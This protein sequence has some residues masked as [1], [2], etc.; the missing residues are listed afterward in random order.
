VPLHPD[1]AVTLEACCILIRERIEEAKG[2]KR[3]EN[4]VCTSLE[5][6]SMTVSEMSY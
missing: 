6:F 2:E 1:P 5:V 4:K 3:E